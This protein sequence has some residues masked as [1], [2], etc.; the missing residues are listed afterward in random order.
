MS[1]NRDRCVPERWI[2]VTGEGQDKHVY[3]PCRDRDLPLH[4]CFSCQRYASLAIDSS[5]KHVYLDCA[6]EGPGDPPPRAV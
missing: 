1:D 3:C 2:E 5:G 4:Q 6:W